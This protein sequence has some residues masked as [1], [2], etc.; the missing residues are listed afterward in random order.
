VYR[1]EQKEFDHSVVKVIR[2]LYE[3]LN[4]R[5]YYS[6]HLNELIEKPESH[7]YLAQITLPV[8]HDSLTSYLQD[9]LEDFGIFTNCQ[10]GLYS[11]VSKKYV[12]TDV[13]TSAGVNEKIR[14]GLPAPSRQN[15]YVALYFPNRQQY[16]LS[17]MNFWII[18]SALLLLV[19]L[20]FSTGIII[21]TAK[22]F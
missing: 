8:N 4:I 20:L 1:F 9:E 2:G 22:N 21:S 10:V 19:L 14:P 18:S 15:D 11:S 17:E 7:L 6:T 3:D 16:I 13:L 5:A 12:F